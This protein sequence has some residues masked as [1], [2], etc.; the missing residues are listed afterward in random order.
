MCINNRQQRERK[1]EREDVTKIASGETHWQKVGD[2]VKR[3]TI[4][5]VEEMQQHEL[6]SYTSKLYAN[7]NEGTT[8]I[9]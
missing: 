3:D 6:T 1:L 8:R 4:E 7:E 9:K 2:V 5:K